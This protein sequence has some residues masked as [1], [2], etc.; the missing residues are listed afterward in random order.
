MIPVTLQIGM[1][2]R[3]QERI[4]RFTEAYIGYAI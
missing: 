3:M 4:A 1:Q 2:E